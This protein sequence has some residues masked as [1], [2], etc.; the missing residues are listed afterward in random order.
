MQT[1]E[2]STNWLHGQG[3]CLATQQNFFHLEITVDYCPHKSLS[4]PEPCVIMCNTVTQIGCAVRTETGWKGMD[5]THLAQ[6]RD[7]W[8]P[9]VNIATRAGFY[10]RP[11]LHGGSELVGGLV[12]EMLDPTQPQA[13]KSVSVA[14]PKL[15]I[16]YIFRYP[17]P[18]KAA[19]SR[20][21]LVT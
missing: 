18:L 17:P 9:T 8:Q 13:G 4:I 10:R 6:H 16:M 21:D 15:L 14:C 12:S 20:C 2:Y 19:A 11:M 7:K 1:D 3:P 5:W